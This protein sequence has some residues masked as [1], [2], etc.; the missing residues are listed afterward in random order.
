VPAP[1]PEAELRAARERPAWRPVPERLKPRV[2]RT[3][4]DSPVRPE[5]HRADRSRLDAA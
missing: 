4:K 2:L 1:L 5:L 3:T